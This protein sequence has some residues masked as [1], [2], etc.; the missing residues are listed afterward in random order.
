MKHENLINKLYP[1][2]KD[3]GYFFKKYLEQYI[4]SETRLLDLGCGR[5]SFGQEYYQK[6]K[7][8]V[9]IDP[10]AEALYDNKLMDEK[11]CLAIQDI[12][13]NF[14]EFDVVIAQWV[15]EHLQNPSEDIKRIS[16]LCKKDGHLI[17]MTTNIYS[18]IIFLSNLF[19]IA[20]K[21]YLRKLFLK[22]NEDD[23]YPTVYKINS[24]AKIDY[25]LSQNSFQKVEMK[26]VGVLTYFSW[27][28]F[29]LIAKILFDRTIGK[30]VPVKTHIVGVY[31]KIN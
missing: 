29:I 26:K 23:T 18:P 13:D 8:K 15:F 9:G 12:P 25:Y 17:F 4:K 27:N 24:I 10:D 28:K 22:I 21:K 20:L 14:G 11:H 1:D 7:I 3:V 30:I 19:P 6:A 2:F 5:Q 16:K 31:K